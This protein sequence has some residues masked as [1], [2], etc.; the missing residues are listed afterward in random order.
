MRWSWS[1][2]KSERRMIR[3]IANRWLPVSAFWV[4]PVPPNQ[5][6]ASTQSYSSNEP[7]SRIFISV[8]LYTGRRTERKTNPKS[9]VAHC[10]SKNDTG[11]A[12]YNF[13]AHPP[14]LVIFGRDVAERVCCQ[15]AICYP[16]S[17]TKC[18]CTTWAKMN[19][20]SENCVFSVTLYT[21]CRKQNCFGLIAT[22]STF[23]NQF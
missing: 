15:M 22:S 1:G 7:H 14:I 21:V 18:L 4:R 12:H 20:N 9:E 11:V 3:H 13:N 19:M 16:T 10:V 5:P 17:P 2:S 8:A 6:A 23:I